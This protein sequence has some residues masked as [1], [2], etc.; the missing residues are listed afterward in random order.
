[1][2]TRVPSVYA[3][4]DCIELETPENES[5]SVQSIWY[6]ARDMGTVA[7][8][9][10]A[11]E[12]R[13]YAPG[14][15]YN[16]AKFFDKEYTSAGKYGPLD[17]GEKDYC[18]Q[19]SRHSIRI[20]YSDDGVKGFSCIGSRW[21]HNRLIRFIEDKSSLSCFLEHHREALFETEFT[22]VFSLGEGVV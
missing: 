6:V 3:A 7:G 1:M 20:I 21:D 19:D 4:G 11:G 8:A 2:E 15:W 13:E 17:D 9:N 14:L 18:Y 22:P 12:S 5:N 10:M 16:S